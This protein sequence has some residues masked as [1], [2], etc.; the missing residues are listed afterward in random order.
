MPEIR[1]ILCVVD[2]TESSQ[3]AMWRAGWLAERTDATLELLVC[4]YNQYISGHRFFDAPSLQR[5]RRELID[6]YKDHLDKLAMPLRESGIKFETAAVWD[7]PLY[8]GIVRHACATGADI[9]IKDTHHHS[10]LD[11]S[12]LSNTDWSLIRTCPVPL[13]LVKPHDLPK[14]LRIVA[15]V[16]PLNEHDKPAALDDEIIATSKYIG[17]RIGADVHVFHAFDPRISIPASHGSVLV[18]MPFDEIE[19]QVR[20]LHEDR[21]NELA[22]FHDLP[23]DQRHVVSGLPH[24]ELPRLAENLNAALVVMGAVSRNRLKRIFLGATSERT[25]DRLPCDL[26]IVKP[27]WF[28]TSVSLTKFEDAQ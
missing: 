11:V 26:L 24:Q 4:F 19:Q 1:K 25:L 18:S 7:H 16:D 20:R 15:A 8:E 12:T 5:T 6:G 3:P 17:T 27:A 28:K 13:W 14:R 10:V 9:V 21:F 22:E 2:P 23:K